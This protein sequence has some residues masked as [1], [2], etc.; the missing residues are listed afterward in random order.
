MVGVR[1]DRAYDEGVRE[2]NSDG[3]RSPSLS[4]QGSET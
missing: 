1:E 4:V 3:P 2:E